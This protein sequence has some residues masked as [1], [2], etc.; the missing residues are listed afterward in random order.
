MIVQARHSFHVVSTCCKPFP[1]SANSAIGTARHLCVYPAI[2]SQ[3]FIK[4]SDPESSSWEQKKRRGGTF[5]VI[6]ANGFDRK[7][8]HRPD[9]TGYTQASADRH[10][11]A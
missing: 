9:P 11:R 6:Y 2:S 3:L 4:R 10:S 8:M 5:L 7:K 1:S